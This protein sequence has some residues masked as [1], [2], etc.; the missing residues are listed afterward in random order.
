[1]SAADIVVRS[2]QPPR[3]AWAGSSSPR[4]AAHTAQLGGGMQRVQVVVRGGYRPDIIRLS[5]A[6]L[7][8]SSS[9]GGEAGPHPPGRCSV[10]SRSAPRFPRS[11]VRRRCSFRCGRSVRV[12]VWDETRPRAPH[13]EA[14]RR[15]GETAPQ[16][17]LAACGSPG[18]RSI[19]C[20]VRLPHQTTLRPTA[21]PHEER[22]ASVPPGR[23]H[24]RHR[25]NRYATAASTGDP[26]AP[27]STEED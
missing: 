4:E 23:R 26:A 7:W 19:P 5:Q 10:T 25:P 1:M 14:G 22:S 9:T 6:Y 27:Q 17:G 21:T 2:P 11:P 12:R 24:L 16:T 8:N 15:T 20:H 13:R 3:A 18:Q